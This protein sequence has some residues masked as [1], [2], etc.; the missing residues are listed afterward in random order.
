MTIYALN[1]YAYIG[2]SS[3][4]KTFTIAHFLDKDDALSSIPALFQKAIE[5]F[6]PKTKQTVRL[7][8]SISEITLLTESIKLKENTNEL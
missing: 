1:I 8:S 3:N 2:K 5:T 6:R 7:L 4:S